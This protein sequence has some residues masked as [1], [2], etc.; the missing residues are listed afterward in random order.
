M[1]T[2]GLKTGLSTLTSMV[3]A[4]L[5]IALVPNPA[6][7]ESTPLLHPAPAPLLVENP[8]TTAFDGK[9]WIFGG[10]RQGEVSDQIWSSADGVDWTLHS[11]STLPTPL[12]NPQVVEHEGR[13]VLIP[14]SGGD[15]AIWA[16]GNGLD[17]EEIAPTGTL[18]NRDW[19][20]ATIHNGE[21]YTISGA[22]GTQVHIQ[23]SANGVEWETVREIALDIEKP[24][25]LESFNGKLALFALEFAGVEAIGHYRI[26]TWTSSTDGIGWNKQLHE[27][28]SALISGHQQPL[29]R[30]YE[31]TTTVWNNRLWLLERGNT[32]LHH[33]HGRN[34]ELLSTTDLTNW[35][36]HDPR[37]DNLSNPGIKPF[38]HPM[39]DS[40]VAGATHHNIPAGTHKWSGSTAVP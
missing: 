16:S 30:S 20:R 34:M 28:F 3:A 25:S 19:R 38:L 29:Y 35:T 27:P 24:M 21:I 40:L 31:L 15:N 6:T 36:R 12:A 7:A 23:R 17:W 9:L 10:T 32:R 26:I 1:N 33:T 2:T 39:G 37:A 14:T 22:V 8:A 5:A 18:S 11:T 4:G 13:L